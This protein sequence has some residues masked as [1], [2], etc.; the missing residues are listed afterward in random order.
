MLEVPVL[1]FHRVSLTSLIV[2][3]LSFSPPSS[4]SLCV[5]L[6]QSVCISL[7]L[8]LSLS[9]SSTLFLLFISL[10]IPVSF[11][12]SL[13]SLLPLSCLYFCLAYSCFTQLMKRMNKNF[14]NGGRAMDTNFANMRSLIQ[15]TVPSKHSS[16]SSLG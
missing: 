2:L 5:C 1:Y 14:P 15:V 13:F 3:Y 6:P 9:L 11:F 16:L 4:L 10:C 8:A 7:S 12:L